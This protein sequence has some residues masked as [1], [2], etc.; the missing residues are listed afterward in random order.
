V[1]NSDLLID[2]LKKEQLF[3]VLISFIDQTREVITSNNLEKKDLRLRLLDDFEVAVRQRL[4]FN[5][6]TNK[7]LNWTGEKEVLSEIF[8]KLKLATNRDGEPLLTNSYED[9]AYFLK[10]NFAVYHNTEISTI[11]GTL[12]K[13]PKKILKDKKD[14]VTLELR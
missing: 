14:K 9:I 7:L 4:A 12:K 10:R 6:S 5:S 1:R 11:A 2:E 13:L 3:K 8:V